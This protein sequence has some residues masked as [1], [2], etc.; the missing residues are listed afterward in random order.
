MVKIDFAEDPYPIPG[1]HI[2]QLTTPYNT[3]SRH[4]DQPLP[5]TGTFTHIHTPN[6]Q[7]HAQTL[8]INTLNLKINFLN[9]ICHS[10][11][12]QASI[13]FYEHIESFP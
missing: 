8:P 12:V 2:R 11:H 4:P 6:T 10:W 9:E 13:T 3:S 5:S 7:T 1:S